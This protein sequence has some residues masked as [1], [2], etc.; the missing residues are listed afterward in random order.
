MNYMKDQDKV[1]IVHVVGSINRKHGGPGEV[2][3]N[4][5]LFQSELGMNVSILT[6]DNDNNILNEIENDID[7]YNYNKSS[8]KENIKI[9]LKD[10]SNETLIFNLHGVW[11]LLL[12]RTAVMIMKHNIPYII[13]PHGMLDKWCLQQNSLK[14]KIALS[15]Y[16]GR[17]FRNCAYVHAL[18]AKESRDVKSLYNNVSTE[19]IPNG[20]DLNLIS[21]KDSIAPE[22]EKFKNDK[23]ILY[24]SR[25]HYKKGLDYLVRAYSELRHDDIK[26]VIAGNDDGYK[27]DIIRDIAKIDP[28]L[29]VEFI[30]PVYNQNKFFML[31]NALLFCLPSRQ[32]GFSVAVLEALGV[33]TPVVIS[34]ACN[35]PEV[36][37]KKA[38]IEYKIYLEDY[39]NTVKSLKVALEFI[40][41]M[42]PEMYLSYSDNAKEM[43]KENYT[44]SKIATMTKNTFNKYL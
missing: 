12:Y 35:F 32:E 15:T 38:G 30:G 24:L 39:P 42:K 5:S 10:C 2:V 4:L 40:L 27:N 26:L 22:F 9:L 37:T 43:I 23:Y 8:F 17:M 20:I 31:K 14:K 16:V 21:L 7:I 28:K 29:K 19:L 44:W 25:I 18:T 33:G 13:T 11:E 41:N 6:D 1:R 36:A 34:D 3:C